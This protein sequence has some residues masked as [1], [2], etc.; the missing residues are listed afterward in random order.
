M[1]VEGDVAAH[2]GER[3]L[4]IEERG[5]LGEATDGVKVARVAEPN[6]TIAR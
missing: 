1:S 4:A 3:D 5:I 2:D 6:D